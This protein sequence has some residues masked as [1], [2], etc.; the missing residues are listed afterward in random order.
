M[1]EITVLIVDDN[2]VIRQGL[3]SLLETEDQIKVAGEASTGLEAINWL[4]TSSA[5]IVLMDIHMPV[6]DGID[7]TMQIIHEQPESKILIITVSED[8]ITLAKAIRAGAKGY[9]VFSLFDPDELLRSIYAIDNG[10]ALP[11][12]PAVEL[13]LADL[14]KV[15]QQTQFMETQQIADPLTPREIEILDLIAD[16][17]SNT[18][19]ARAL[20][21]EE[22]TVKNHITRLYSKINVDNRYEAIR[23][24]LNRVR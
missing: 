24:K 16:G 6:I 10:E 13:A 19:I 1:S 17:R 23:Y 15:E 21:V 12:T 3:R 5:D 8:S 14:P 11:V 20:I 22:K 4:R 7:A 2:L 18:E 9:I